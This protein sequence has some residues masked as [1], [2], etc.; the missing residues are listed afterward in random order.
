LEDHVPSRPIESLASLICVLTLL[1]CQNL[2]AQATA[3]KAPPAESP[4]KK[5]AAPRT[6]DGQ[7]D[8][9]GT[10]TNATVTPFQRPA[11]LGTK[12]FFTAEEA[13]TFEKQRVEQ[14]N[15]DRIEGERGASD[16]A[17]RSYNNFWTDRGTHVAKTMHTSLVVDPPDGKVP[18]F[19]PEAQ[20]RFDAVRAYLAQHTADSPE[21]RYL[22]ERC[23]LFGAA[24][25]PMLPEPYNNNYEIVQSRGF[26]AIAVEMN[27]ETRIVPL[28]GSPHL[29]AQIRQWTGD[30]RGHW[31]GDTLV[32][33]S[34]NFKFNDQSRFGVGYLD[35]MTD[36]NLHVVERFRR[37]D[38]STIMY[39]ATVDDPS[40]YTKPWTVE[41]SIAKRTD[42]IFEYACHEGNYGMIG[43]LSGARAEE[44]KAAGVTP[45][46]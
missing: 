1:M 29:P 39:Q 44:K 16:L 15:V 5:W 6:P 11:Q 14:G 38:P 34:T 30:S 37:T 24:G 33:D 4:A 25:P 2:A 42:R 27:H 19:T 23:I 17:R 12:Q 40:V 46:P 28:D 36:E 22:S 13:A 3:A 43:I 32:V 8:L 31:E 18:P 21:D 41:I 35:G 9:Q 45:K 7:P 20:M 26:V 10:W